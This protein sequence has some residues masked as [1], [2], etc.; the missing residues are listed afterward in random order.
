MGLLAT[1]LVVGWLIGIVLF[2]WSTVYVYQNDDSEQ[3]QRV[4]DAMDND[5]VG[6][7]LAL[8]VLILAWPATL[9]FALHQKRK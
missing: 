4:R 1:V 9:A 8:T 6:M 2:I 7:S 5:P 3:T